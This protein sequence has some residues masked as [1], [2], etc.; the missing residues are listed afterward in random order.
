MMKTNLGKI[1]F[2]FGM[3]LLPFM[4]NA[5]VLLQAPDTFYKNDVV[6]FKIVAAGT[7]ISIPVIKNIDGQRVEN[8]GTAKHTT[9]INGARSYQ[10]VNTYALIG[11]QD[12]HIPSFDIMIDNKIEKTQSKIIKMLKVEKTQSDLYN[13][14]V[15][16]DKKDVYVGEAI[17]YTLK[18]K[19]KKDLEIV[20]L[21]YTKPSFENFWVKELKEEPTQN[22]YTKYVEQE[23]KYLLFPQQAG[24]I[25]LE[26]IKIGVNT[27]KN[28]YGRGFTLSSPTLSTP[29]YSNKLEINVKSLPKGINLIGDF[30][31]KATIDKTEIDAG[32]A[33]SYKLYITGRG[34]IDDLDEVIVAI[35]NTTIYDNPSEKEYNI[36]DNLYGGKY[37]KTYSIIGKKDFIMPSVQVRYFD[38]K[39][40]TVKTTKT[41]EYNIK[42]NEK[43]IK[44]SKLEIAAIPTPI[45]SVLSDQKQ[46][47]VIVQTTDNDKIIYFVF[48]LLCGVLL[49]GIYLILIK[50]DTKKKE[51]PLFTSIK[52]T[53]TPDE[54]FKILV[55]YINIDEE[56]DK[57]I[58]KLENISL[59]EYKKEK[60]NILKVLKEFFKKDNKSV[61]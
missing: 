7:D 13:L 15:A 21:D 51:T 28:N 39:T 37:S 59:E 58:Y 61:I 49:I 34:N 9:I 35:P 27:I 50:K 4:V 25:V 19:Y 14:T 23:I 38:K 60:S 44:E 55:V 6:T 26:P 30:T 36:K 31:I 29:V 32:D 53:K 22:N 43:E 3:I 57:I 5:K 2:I 1:I 54:L 47:I 46:K 52:K 20:S 24:K 42:V 48:G 17:E 41:K 11:T 12:I 10:F 40:Q 16:I 33:V 45:A 56:L 8:A 18:F